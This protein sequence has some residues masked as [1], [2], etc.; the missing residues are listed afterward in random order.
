MPLPHTLKL[1][2]ESII[3]ISK[4]LS[5]TKLRI[6]EYQRPYTWNLDNIASLLNDIKAQSDK[7]AYRLGT[8][9]LNRSKDL[10]GNPVL[11]IVDGQ[12]RSLT[13]MLI[14]LAVVENH[15]HLNSCKS[16][17]NSENIKNI[18]ETVIQVSETVKK[19]AKTL[20]FSSDISVYNLHNNFQEISRIVRRGEFKIE[21][22]DFLLNKC[23]V[24]IFILDELSEAFQFF[25]SQNSRGKALY[26][27]DLLKAFH[28]REFSE[29]DDEIN[30]NIKAQSVAH[31]ESLEDSELHNLFAKHLFRIKRWIDKK[32]ARHFNSRHIDIFKGLSLHK[33]D[34]PHYAKSLLTIHNVIDE[35]NKHLNNPTDNQR[36][37]YPFQLDQKVINGRRFFE[38][39]HHYDVLVK[40]V[41]SLETLDSISMIGKLQQ[42]NFD[43][44]SNHYLDDR[45]KKIVSKLNN[46]D[47]KHRQGDKY[48]R[49][50]FDNTLIYYIDKFGTQDLS[51]VIRIVFI[52]AYKVRLK[53]YAVKLATMDNYALESDFFKRIK[54]ATL[55]K[56][57]WIAGIDSLKDSDVVSPNKKED[58]TNTIYQLFDELDYLTVD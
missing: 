12:Q 57:V 24:V 41:K 38:M 50:L 10:E 45:A 11:N 18:K 52:W 39:V 58:K 21:H 29:Y 56:D 32:P 8:I 33:P 48:V 36:I 47:N 43:T 6:P 2:H 9:V 55:S 54:E 7:S 30:P 34:L 44:V 31:W 37:D 17:L 53:H 26:P 3:P 42:N 16:S 51:L 23:E 20:K 40:Q 14:V 19:L 4:L 13:L 22:I 5:E 1:K 15:P 28:L 49:N 27:H 25:D 46:Y 35:Y